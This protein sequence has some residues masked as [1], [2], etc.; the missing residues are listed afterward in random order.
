VRYPFALTA[1]AFG[2]HFEAEQNEPRITPYF[3]EA[4]TQGR[5]IALILIINI[6]LG[7]LEILW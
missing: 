3:D 4:A 7:V 2:L 5:R 1:K 6:I